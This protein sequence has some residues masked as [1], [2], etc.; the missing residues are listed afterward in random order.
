[1]IQIRDYKSDDNIVYIPFSKA[2]R[3]CN[4]SDI[5]IG[6]YGPPVFQI[7]KG[8]TGAY[9]VA[10]MKATPDETILSKDYLFYFL[11]YSPVQEYI[12]GLSDRAAGQSGINKTALYNYKISIPPLSEQNCIVTILDGFL[13]RIKIIQE[14]TKQNLQYTKELFESYIQSVFANGGKGWE[15]RNLSEMLQETELVDPKKTPDMEF[16]YIDVSSVNKETKT[17]ENP[18]KIIGKYAPSRARKLIKSNDVIYATVRPTH[19]R[20][21][22]ITDEFD[23]QICSTGY[24]VLRPTRN[25]NNK[26][27]YYYLQTYNIFKKMEQ[28]QRGASYPAVTD[29]DIKSLVISFPISLIEQKKIVKKIQDLASEIEHLLEIYN[30]KLKT[31]EELKKSI[32]QKAFNGELTTKEIEEAI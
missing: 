14:N 21:A 26:L 16:T 13:S 4:D 6:R 10:L 8:L 20:V 25:L 23:N 24:C 18:I 28:L 30:K 31:L 3:F 17:I 2:R 1:L 29:N 7:L 27:L 22:Y 15:K 5:M 12:I 32:L 11:K 19:L 9:N